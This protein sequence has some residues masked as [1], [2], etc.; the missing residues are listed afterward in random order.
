MLRQGGEGPGCSRVSAETATSIVSE[1]TVHVEAPRPGDGRG[2]AAATLDT[3]LWP[4]RAPGPPVHTLPG[5]GAP[6]HAASRLANLV[7]RTNQVRCLNLVR[8]F[9]TAVWLRRC[10]RR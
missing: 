10:A 4:T 5:P 7:Q 6:G 2:P 3:T 9:R 8:E 1:L